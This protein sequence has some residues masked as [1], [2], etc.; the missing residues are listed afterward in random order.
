MYST[1]YQLVLDHFYP[2]IIKG[3]RPRGESYFTLRSQNE[4][5]APTS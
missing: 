1:K 5:P 4:M 2:E 3:W